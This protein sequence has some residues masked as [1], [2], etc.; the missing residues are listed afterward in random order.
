MACISDGTPK[1]AERFELY[2]GGLE[3]VNGYWELDDA[4]EQR[5][6]FVEEQAKLV[7]LGR[8]A[9][10]LD[11]F[12]LDALSAGF[13]DTSG[14]ALGLDRLVMIAAGAAEISEV[15]AFPISRA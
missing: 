9:P 1:A 10:P 2:I 4:D 13:P 3:I 15:L 12:L 5:E 7:E 8:Q 14:A 6:R 11:G